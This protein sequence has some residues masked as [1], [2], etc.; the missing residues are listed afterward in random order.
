MKNF[1]NI[2][3]HTQWFDFHFG[4]NVTEIQRSEVT[5]VQFPC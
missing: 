2:S 5:F 1:L 3:L 4:D